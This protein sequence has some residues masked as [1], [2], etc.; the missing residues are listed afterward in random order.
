MIR[1]RVGAGAP[2]ARLSV[3]A[4]LAALIA[5]ACGA[6][7]KLITLPTVAGS[8]VDAPEAIEALADAGRAC[9]SVSTITAAIGVS[10]SIGGRRVPHGHL[11]AGVTR[12]GALRLEATVPLGG[13]AFVFVVRP[14]PSQGGSGSAFES[15]LLLPRDNRVLESRAP[16]DVLEALTGVPLEPSELRDTLTGCIPAL[17]GVQ[18]RGRNWIV[19]RYAENEAYLTRDNAATPWRV[20]AVVHADGTA[21]TWRAEYRDFQS[22][23]PRT[24]HLA[25]QDGRFN[26]ALTLSD[27]DINTDIDSAAFTVKVPPSAVPITLE[28]LRDAGALQ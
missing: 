24:I 25:A 16:R 2:T 3:M 11:I 7:P 15:T 6:P 27:V 23:L 5:A 26:L 13:T 22:G 10:G 21:A 8:P 17:L 4:A 12:T 20:A 9:R 28:E 18:H 19:G 1:S 14:A